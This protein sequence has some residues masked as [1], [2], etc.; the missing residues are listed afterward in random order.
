MKISSC[1]ISL[2]LAFSDND[3][4]PIKAKTVLRMLLV[5]LVSS[6]LKRNFS[7]SL[8]LTVRRARQ[9]QEVGEEVEDVEVGGKWLD[10]VRRGRDVTEERLRV[11][12]FGSLRVDSENT[13]VIHG[14][15]ER[16][17][18]QEKEHEEREPEKRE[19]V[20]AAL[21]RIDS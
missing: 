18:G 4:R 10:F 14:Q 8:R 19:V 12:S 7:T 6:P 9:R 17:V 16:L 3:Y 13:P 1:I 5:R 21:R 2:V 11:T 20:K 15:H